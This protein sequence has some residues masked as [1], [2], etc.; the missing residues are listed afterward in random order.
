MAQH[1]MALHSTTMLTM[2]QLHIVAKPFK[3]QS[4]E[5]RARNSDDGTSLIT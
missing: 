4:E 2:K 3:S 1:D 5:K